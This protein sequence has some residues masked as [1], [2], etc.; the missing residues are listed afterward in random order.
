MKAHVV[1]SGGVIKYEQFPRNGADTCARTALEKRLLIKH[2]EEVRNCILMGMRLDE[3]RARKRYIARVQ[4]I[5]QSIDHRRSL[6]MDRYRRQR[7]P[8][9]HNSNVLKAIFTCILKSHDRLTRFRLLCRLPR[10]NRH[11]R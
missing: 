4:R 10:I 9:S 5:I 11:R 7:A 8:S 6:R 1:I 2:E 3:E